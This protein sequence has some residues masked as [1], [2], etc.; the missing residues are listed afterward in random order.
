MNSPL[1]Y[2]FRSKL[3]KLRNL[4]S[5]QKFW[6]IK[7]PNNKFWFRRIPHEKWKRQSSKIKVCGCYFWKGAD[8]CILI[9][10]NSGWPIYENPPSHT[11]SIPT[12]TSGLFQPKRGWDE[13]MRHIILSFLNFRLRSWKKLRFENI[14]HKLPITSLRVTRRKRSAWKQS[15]S[16]N[17]FDPETS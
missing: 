16:L 4:E 12:E 2:L 17:C 11:R 7:I 13:Q 9:W 3:I 14:T 8:P 1:G 15:S 6:R 10:K 5:S